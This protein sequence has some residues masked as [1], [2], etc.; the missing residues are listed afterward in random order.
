VA[1][2]DSAGTLA[3]ARYLLFD[4]SPTEKDD[5]FG[6]TFYSEIDV[7]DREVNETAETR[8]TAVESVEI[9]GSQYRFTVETTEAPDLTEWARTELIPVMK[10]WYP[11]IASMLPSEGYTAPRTFS[12]IFTDAYRGVAATMGNRIEC[13]PSWYR[14]N[15]KGEAIGSVVHELVHVVQQYRGRRGQGATRPPGWL[16]EGIPDYIRWF[17][18]E[19]QTRGAEIRPENADRAR[20][21]A[22][23]RTSANFLNWVVTKYD[24]DLVP[25]LNR[26]LCEGRYEPEIWKTRTGKTVEELA[27][28]W[29]AALKA[30]VP[31]S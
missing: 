10:T 21:D 16:I 13:S 11:K 7:L 20:Y 3:S 23:Y 9:E 8:V 31:G 24:K 17:L 12:I 6:N 2:S 19:P 28:E 30:P 29:K 27:E 25:E 14:R 4:I 22:S 18:Y 5:P 1:I 26:A 15:L